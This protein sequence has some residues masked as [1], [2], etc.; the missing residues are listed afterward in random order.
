IPAGRVEDRPSG[1]WDWLATFAELAGLPVPAASDGVSLLPTLTGRG[2]RRPG[3]LYLEYFNN[4]RTPDYP[5]FARSHRGRQRGQ[6]QVVHLDG[7]KGVRYNVKSAEDDFEIYHVGR[8]P[9]ETNNL[10]SDP[11]FAGLQASLKARALRVRKPDAS[12]KRPYDEAF[13]PS[14][15]RAPSSPPG[16]TWSWFKGEWPW[17]P[18][19]RTLAP[20]RSGQ[21]KGIDLPLEAGDQ[22]FGLAF[23]GF[24][25]AAEDGDYIF[26]LESDCGAMLFLHEIRVVEEPAKNPAG[27]VS[28]SIRLQAGWHPFRLYYRHAGDRPHLELDCQLAGGE[29]LPLDET[30]FRQVELRL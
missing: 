12:A 28:G 24:F 17:M 21:A 19:F 22:S 3:I 20:L 6:M 26:T 27:K 29:A 23:E 13:V 15:A 7:Y 4:T 2:D 9:Q 18:D 8:D 11:S 25:H 30:G 16:L 5:E 10:A 1:Q 14:M